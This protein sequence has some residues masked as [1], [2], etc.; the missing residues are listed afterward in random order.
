MRGNPT[1]PKD[2]RQP[3][4]LRSSNTG[5]Q[6]RSGGRGADLARPAEEDVFSWETDRLVSAHDCSMETWGWRDG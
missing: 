3:F 5:H 2:S 6:E 1:S 4:R